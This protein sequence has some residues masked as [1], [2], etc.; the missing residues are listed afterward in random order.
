M[1]CLASEKPKKAKP[2]KT[3]LQ[4]LSFKEFGE[5]NQPFDSSP[6]VIFG[7][8]QNLFKQKS[9]HG[10]S[11]ALPQRARHFKDQTHFGP[12]DIYFTWFSK[13][14]CNSQKGLSVSLGPSLLHP[15]SQRMTTWATCRWGWPRR[16]AHSA[17]WQ[18]CPRIDF[19]LDAL[20]L[21]IETKRK[22]HKLKVV[23]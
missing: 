12:A 9:H 18:L 6:F 15:R 5:P 1:M 4:F 16:P 17:P 13:P 10:L 14:A 7:L 8:E 21:I 2:K 22:Q 20:G 19:F 3:T 11:A 23:F